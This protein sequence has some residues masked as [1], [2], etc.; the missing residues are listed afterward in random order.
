MKGLAPN[1]IMTIDGRSLLVS[2]LDQ[3]AIGIFEPEAK[4]SLIPKTYS[5][6]KVHGKVYVLEITTYRQEDDNL[7]TTYQVLPE[8]EAEKYLITDRTGSLTY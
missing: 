7:L 2:Y 8:K 5:L 4:A 3:V 1:K 6:Y